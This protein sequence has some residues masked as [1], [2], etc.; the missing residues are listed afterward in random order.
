MLKNQGVRLP[1]QHSTSLGLV[2]FD[3]SILQY[4][5]NFIMPVDSPSGMAT[6]PAP[7][8]D[9]DLSRL[10]VWVKALETKVNSL[11]RETDI[12]K[13]DFLKKN[14]QLLRDMKLLNGEVLEIKHEHEKTLQKMDLVIKELQQTAGAEEVL[15]LRKYVDLWNPLHFATQRDVERAVEE[16][17]AQNIKRVP[18]SSR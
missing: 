8:N 7:E 12:L 2:V 16:K 17:M 11:L 3:I 10:Y 9:F 6:A 14:N 15:T 1:P 18:A 13:N 4:S 5:H